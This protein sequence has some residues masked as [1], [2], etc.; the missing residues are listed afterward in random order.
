M[1][2]GLTRP[3]PL[4]HFGFWRYLEVESHIFL[5]TRSIYAYPRNNR[6][7]SHQWQSNESNLVSKPKP[8]RTRIRTALYHLQYLLEAKSRGFTKNTAIGMRM[9]EKKKD[10][11][12]KFCVICTVLA[13]N[14]TRR[15]KLKESSMICP[16]KHLVHPDVGL[17]LASRNT[18]TFNH[19]A[20]AQGLPMTLAAH[21]L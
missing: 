8:G 13:R 17:E 11:V 12:P 3:V 21:E 16:I 4:G 14:F 6:P 5:V 15:S 9:G 20:Q 1:S 7:S 10:D 18:R 19:Q 2:R